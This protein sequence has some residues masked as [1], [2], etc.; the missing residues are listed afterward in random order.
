MRSRVIPGSSVTIDRRVP[1]RRLKIVDL[2]TLGRPTITTE[3]SFA[4]IFLPLRTP[5]HRTGGSEPSSLAYRKRKQKRG[6]CC[7]GSGFNSNAQTGRL[8]L[9]LVARCSRHFGSTS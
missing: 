9:T 5:E 6:R 8:I 2:P 4:V 1:V 7:R 3:E